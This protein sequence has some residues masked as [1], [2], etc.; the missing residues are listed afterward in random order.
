MKALLLALLLAVPVVARADDAMPPKAAL[1]GGCHGAAG[2]PAVKGVPVIWGQNEGYLYI[3]LRDYKLGNRSNP[4]MQAIAGSL[5]KDEM[6][7]LAAYFGARPWPNLGQAT[8]PDAVLRQAQTT[9]ASAQC[10]QCHLGTYLGASATPRVA[11]QRIDYLR[12]TMLAFRGN[13][14]KNNSWMTALLGTYSDADI[15]TLAQYLAGM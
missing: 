9:A 13:T 10:P 2:V 4:A 8:A 3:E 5:E 11:G 12:A 1:C 6:K 14:R 15:E 7:A